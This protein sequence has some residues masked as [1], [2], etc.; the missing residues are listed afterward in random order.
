MPW[1]IAHDL[2]VFIRPEDLDTAI[3]KDP[4]C[5]VFARACQ[6]TFGSTK[7]LFFRYTAYVE[8]PDKDGT[9]RVER[10]KMPCNMR[11]LVESFDR[12]EA[13]IPEAG[14]LLKAPTPA[15]S[16][17]HLRS[18]SYQKFKASQEKARTAGQSKNPPTPGSGKTARPI[19]VDMSVRHGTGHAQF[20]QGK[21]D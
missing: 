17:E 7:V 11:A 18:K 9:L 1:S 10:F 21:K 13:V 15:Q 20:R 14:F 5:C 12:G 8:L 6:R 2:R 3:P 16:L 19:S 4:G